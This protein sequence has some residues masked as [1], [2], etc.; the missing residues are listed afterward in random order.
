MEKDKSTIIVGDFNIPFQPTDRTIILEI[1]NG[2][3]LN[4]TINQ[5]D[6]IKIC[7]H[8][9]QQQIPF[10]SNV[11]GT[12]PKID[13]ILGHKPTFNQIKRIK[14]ITIVFS[15]RNGI[16]VEINNKKTPGKY[17]YTWKFKKHTYK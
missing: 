12:F 11:F 5:Q 10:Y 16:K 8:S 14:I 4:N 2:K 17:L 7:K 13:H 9:T 3:D 1:S 6:P 15:D